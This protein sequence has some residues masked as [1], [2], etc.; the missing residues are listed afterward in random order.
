MKQLET[1]K[2]KYKKNSTAT[3]VINRKCHDLGPVA[4]T[5]IKSPVN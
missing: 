2:Q 4:P 5:S 3:K 1:C